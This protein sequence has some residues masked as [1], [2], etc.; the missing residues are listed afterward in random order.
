MA[1]EIVFAVLGAA[2]GY[3][4]ARSVV[5]EAD[6]HRRELADRWWDPVCG[7]CGGTLSPLLVRCAANRH[8]QRVTNLVVVI[9]L[10]ALCAALPFVLPAIW[11]MPAYVGFVG[12]VVLLTITDIDTQLIPNRILVR[13][14]VPSV[15]ALCIGGLADAEPGAVL[16]GL[17]GAVGYFLFMLVLA[18]IARGALG[19]GDVKLASLIGAFTA[20]LGWGELA[21]SAVG[22]FLIAGIAAIALLVTRRASRTDHIAFGPFMVLASLIAVYAGPAILDWYTA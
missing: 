5:A 15:V 14:G 3:V 16:R 7:E 19:F 22:S 13:A 17:A 18:L 4:I 10:P 12:T 2:A 9:V 21:L 8:R 1:I 20:Y 6:A 11:V